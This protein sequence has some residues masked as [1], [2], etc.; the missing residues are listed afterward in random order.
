[1]QNGKFMSSIHSTIFSAV[2]KIDGEN[3]D[4]DNANGI[5]VADN[6]DNICKIGSGANIDEDNANGIAVADNDD[7]ICK[8]GSGA[9][10]GANIEEDNANVAPG[11]SNDNKFPIVP[12]DH[13]VEWEHDMFKHTQQPL[14]DITNVRQP[15][16]AIRGNCRDASG[17][18]VFHFML[19]WNS[20]ELIKPICTDGYE[21]RKH[22]L[23]YLLKHRGNEA[24]DNLRDIVREFIKDIK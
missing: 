19:L 17:Y 2:R 6:D 3:I 18:F 16:N 4:E 9:I 20:K 1:M 15:C 21:L 10:D 23:L 8:I 24:R 5:A 11:L 7:N 14:N 13:K 12:W 22:F